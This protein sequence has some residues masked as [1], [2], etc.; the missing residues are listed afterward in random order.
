MHGRGA[1]LGV[2]LAALTSTGPAMA[3]QTVE[4]LSFA[5]LDGWPADDH[6]AALS[7]FRSTCADLEGPEWQ[8]LCVLAEG[9]TDARTFSSL[10]PVAAT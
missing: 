10:F 8:P 3:E 1:I 4:L 2:V 6:A 5:D 9:A 7:V